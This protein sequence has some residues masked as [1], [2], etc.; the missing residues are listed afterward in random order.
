MGEQGKVVEELKRAD[1]V[2]VTYACDDTISFERVSTHWLPQLQKLEVKAPVLVVGCKLDLRDESR[3]VSLESLT[4]GIMNQ[5]REV[6]TCIE[7]SAAT[8]YQVPEVFYFAQKAALHPVDPL[9]DYDTNALTDRCVRA[10]RRIFNLFDYNMD[11]TLTDHEVNEFQIRS[12][13]ASLQQPDI[14]QLKTMV[15][16][17]VPEGVNSLGLTFPGFIEIH[18]MFL[19]KGRTETFWA[20]LR[21]FG[22]GNDLKL[23]DDFLPVPSKKA[24]DQSVELSGAAI[25]FL[26]GVFRL[27]DTDKDQLLQPAEVDKLFDAAPESPWKDAPYMDAAETTDMGYISLKGFLSQWALM[28]LL[29]PRYSLANLICIGYR[30]NPSA[31][32]RL[33]SRRS[34][35]RKNQKTERNVFQ[36]YVFGSKTA[37]KSAL[38]CSLLGRP[39]SN[40]YTPTT[41]E[42]YAANIIELI[43][44][45]KKTLILREIPEDEVSNFLS[46]KDCLAACDVAA[47]VHDSSDG[48][49]WKRSIDLLEKVVNQGELTGHRFPCLLIAAKD[50][51]T[52]FPRAVLDS[53]KVA[54]ELKIDA[55]IRL[56]IKSD[57][58]NNVYSKIINAA[59]HPHLSIPETEFVRKR[60]QHQ[61]LL[62]TFIFALAGAAMALAGFTARRARANRNSS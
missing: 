57:D 3:Q 28:T 49:S 42:R 6:V 10:L 34:E 4:T 19:K 56:S 16:R 20:V 30:D 44:G 18:N 60:K 27:V 59:E 9:F 47:F 54:Q 21:K 58:S 41:V 48:Y 17:N 24:S 61:Q 31:A 43:A 39:F 37:G 32:L 7:C 53:V 62:H 11:G 13:G 2:I 38:L 26:K 29:D 14:T 12:F 5:F 46:N 23:R 51:L 33:T 52:P 22:Y 15:L 25:E 45:T 50:D 1:S 40:D 36:C 8:L 35:D 55:P